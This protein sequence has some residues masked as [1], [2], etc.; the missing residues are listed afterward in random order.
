MKNM[1][2]DSVRPQRG[3]TGLETA[4]ILIAFVVVASVFAFTILSAGVQ[5][6]EANKQTVA[7]GL[8]ETRTLLLQQGSAFAWQGDLGGS[9]TVY[10]VAFIVANSLAG[11]PIDMT[12]PYTA[13]DSGTDPDYDSTNSS[14]VVVSYADEDQRLLDIP[15]TIQF[16]GKSNG[17]NLLEDGEK[18]EVTVWL[19][20]RDTSVAITAADSV[21]Y[22]DGTG[23]G[24]GAG[25]I[26]SSGT[27]LAKSTRFIVELT[28]QQGASLTIQ[29]TLPPGLRQVMNLQ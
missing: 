18:A 16:I 1:R 14:V 19:L 26:D 3:I 13:D 12:P 4:I 2:A 9:D 10:K 7:A 17:D 24:G 22:M 28:P 25:G 11:E 23:D 29:R 15:W 5:S 6:S 20:D 8:K 27:L 21:A